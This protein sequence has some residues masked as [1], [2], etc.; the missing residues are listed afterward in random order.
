MKKKVMTLKEVAQY[1]K[2]S[3]SCIIKLVKE[4]QIP[5][6]R[7]GYRIYFEENAINEWIEIKEKQ[8]KRTI[9]F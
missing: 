5:F 4:K 7:V 2:M 1:L 9:L 3:E 6:F 8:E